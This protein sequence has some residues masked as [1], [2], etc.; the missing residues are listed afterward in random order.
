MKLPPMKLPIG[1]SD[2][3]TVIDEKFNF[4]DKTL[5]IKDIIDDSAKVILI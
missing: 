5:F 2:F 4:V 3:K 1:E